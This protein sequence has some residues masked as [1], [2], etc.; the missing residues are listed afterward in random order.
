MEKIRIRYSIM[1]WVCVSGA[2]KKIPDSEKET[3]EQ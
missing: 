1:T 3:R 2:P